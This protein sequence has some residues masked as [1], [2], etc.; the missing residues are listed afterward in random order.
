VIYESFGAEDDAVRFLAALS[1]RGGWSCSS[2]TMVAALAGGCQAGEAG[3]TDP[4]GRQG[5]EVSKCWRTSTPAAS[6][7]SGTVAIRPPDPRELPSDNGQKARRSTQGCAVP[8]VLLLARK[9]FGIR[10]GMMM[11]VTLFV[12]VFAGFEVG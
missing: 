11:D 4:Q 9:L 2:A 5:P 3:N 8:E 6:R 10:P 12:P 1:G 7:L